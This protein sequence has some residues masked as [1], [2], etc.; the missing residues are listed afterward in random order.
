MS[1]TPPIESRDGTVL[2]VESAGQGPPL[3]LVH[4]VAIDRRCWSGLL[5]ELTEHFTVHSLNRRGR[6]DGPAEAGEYDIKREGEDIAAV[7]EAVGRDVFVVAHSYGALCSLEAALITNSIGRMALYEPPAPGHPL[8]TPAFL[9]RLRAMESAGDLAGVLD[10]F[11]RHVLSPEDL[12]GVQ[13]PGSWEESL[14]NTHT[15]VRELRCQATFDTSDRL[16]KVS[17]PIKFL[18]GTESP[19][20]HR[21]A[22]EALSTHL[23]TTELTLLKGQGHLANVKAPDQ[24]AAAILNDRGER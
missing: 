18:L 1:S 5:P 2:D 4:G 20:Y 9:E 23:P 8:L 21:R 24:F 17:V 14:A 7:A 11:G 15:V 19:P 12:A 10:T 22:I 16:A 6:K 3:L 13:A